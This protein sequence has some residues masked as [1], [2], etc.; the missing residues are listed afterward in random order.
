MGAKSHSS[1]ARWLVGWA[2]S[3]TQKCCEYFSTAAEDLRLS[4]FASR[5]GVGNR[6]QLSMCGYNDA[7]DRRDLHA[8]MS[9][10]DGNGEARAPA[11]R[12]DI[13]QGADG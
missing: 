9:V 7:I 4:P 3:L 5:D 6:G 2:Q 1:G 12:L 13:Q 8:L 11:G 10:R